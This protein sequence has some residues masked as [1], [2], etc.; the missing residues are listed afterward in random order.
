MTDPIADLLAQIKNAKLARKTKV[1][2][3]HSKVKESLAQILKKEGYLKKVE[4]K[5]SSPNKL[6]I[7]VDLAYDGKNPKL[8]EVVCVSK[9]SRRIYTPFKKIPHVLGGLGTV[10][11]STSYGLMTGKEARKKRIGGEVICKV[12]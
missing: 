10:I 5:K 8:T 3:E 2:V 1:E 4:I 6:S 11:I 12:W 9:P 7:A